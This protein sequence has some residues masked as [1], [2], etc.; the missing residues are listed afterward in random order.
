[1]SKTNSILRALVLV[2]AG[3]LSLAGCSGET[4]EPPTG[5]TDDVTPPAVELGDPATAEGDATE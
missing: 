5:A 1:M 3:L 2:S 4:P